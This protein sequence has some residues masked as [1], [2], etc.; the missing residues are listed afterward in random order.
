[1]SLYAANLRDILAGLLLFVLAMAYFVHGG[2]ALSRA[3]KRVNWPDGLVRDVTLMDIVRFSD[4]D[5]AANA[6]IFAILTIFFPV[7]LNVMGNLHGALAVGT[8]GWSTLLYY[9]CMAG[10][11]VIIALEFS[12]VYNL[13]D[14]A[15]NWTPVLL[16]AIVLDIVT[17]LVLFL[18]VDHP[19][20][21]ARAFSETQGLRSETSNAAVAELQLAGPSTPTVLAMFLATG[22]ALTSSAMIIV[23]ARA[24][25]AVVD[26][27]VKAAAVEKRQAAVM[28]SAPEQLYLPLRRRRR[29]LRW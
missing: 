12:Y 24:A 7:L 23:F 5:W 1:M 10:V 11:S 22:V 9:A 2:I 27:R 14:S 4:D 8:L 6:W 16:V 29:A 25:G 13:R 17:L 18:V 20:S 3:R 28:G 19:H 15:S 21:W 26:G